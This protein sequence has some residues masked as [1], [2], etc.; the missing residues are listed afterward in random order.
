MG[1]AS[2]SPLT[3]VLPRPVEPQTA[4]FFCLLLL[5]MLLLLL[6]PLVLPSISCRIRRVATCDMDSGTP[7]VESTCRR[8]AGVRLCFATAEEERS[9][10]WY[11]LLSVFE[12]PSGRG[13]TRIRRCAS[14]ASTA[15]ARCCCCC[16]FP[17]PEEALLALVLADDED[18][19]TP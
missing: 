18:V 14:A 16:S 17:R 4:L 2:S 1:S 12:D 10:D 7:V 3:A 8:P 19:P 9:I 11:R 5:L 6:L 13:T 15:A